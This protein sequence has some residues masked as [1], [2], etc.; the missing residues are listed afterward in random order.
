MNFLTV[1]RGPNTHGTLCAG[2]VPPE[3]YRGVFIIIERRSRE[4]HPL[5]ATLELATLSRISRE[6]HHLLATLK[7]A[8]LSLEDHLS[9]AKLNQREEDQ[10][11]PKSPPSVLC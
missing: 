1:F 6:A 8:I 9:R 11:V 3:D 7:L 10:W 5:L 2:L 4:A